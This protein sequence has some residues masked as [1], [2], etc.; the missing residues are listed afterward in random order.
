MEQKDLEYKLDD[1]SLAAHLVPGYTTYKVINERTLNEKL[2]K[3]VWL[4]AALTFELDLL[5]GY[6]QLYEEVLK[7]IF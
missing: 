1:I 2:N 5:M 3:I 7:K 6:Y 4:G